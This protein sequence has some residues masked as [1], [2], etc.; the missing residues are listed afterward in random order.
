MLLLAL[1]VAGS[2][3]GK[4][5]EPPPGGPSD[6]NAP[7]M[8]DLGPAS[9]PNEGAGIDPSQAGAGQTSREPG[10]Q[11]QGRAPQEQ[12]SNTGSP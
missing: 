2:G 11:G 8:V 9:A 4:P 10:T 3:C 5:K 6:P 1:V 7:P 12:P